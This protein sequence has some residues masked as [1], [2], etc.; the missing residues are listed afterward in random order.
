MKNQT[1]KQKSS[2]YRIFLWPFKSYIRIIIVV[3][4]IGLFQYQSIQIDILAR[5]IRSLELEKK[6]LLDEGVVLQVDIDRLTHINRIEK[7][8]REKYG[9]ISSSEEISRLQVKKFKQTDTEN[10]NDLKLAGVR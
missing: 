3:G 9:L 2:F 10:A 1:G 4:I 7:L 8:A 5:E 6:Q